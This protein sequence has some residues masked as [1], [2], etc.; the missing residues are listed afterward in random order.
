MS[1]Y[2]EVAIAAAR[3][4]G[5]LQ[6][7]AYHG[8][9]VV[10]ES[11]RHDIKLQ[12]DVDCEEAIRGVVLQA[13]PDHAV[14]GE[15]GGGTLPADRPAWII[16]P[17][18]GTVNY[19]RRLPHF[20]TSI[21]LQVQGRVIAAVVYHPLLDELYTAEEGAGA[22]LNGTR[23]HVSDTAELW[24]AN[25]AIGFAKSQETIARGLGKINELAQSVSKIR[26]MGA[27]ALEMAYVA[28][29]RFDGFIEYGLRT[30]DIAAGTLLIRE[31]GGR[32]LL[33]PRGELAWDVWAD[34]GR[35]W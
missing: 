22:Y 29:G 19:S 2:L 17:L 25:M 11:S 32:V 23:L 7:Q 5:E 15:E 8:T 1:E 3:V 35:I 13:F 31:A 34:N 18:D 26:I 33:I 27:A 20:C 12:T 9:L 14:L 4:A 10:R 21:A 16:D 30:W 28:A 6:R 24:A